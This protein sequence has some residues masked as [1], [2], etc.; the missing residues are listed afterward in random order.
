MFTSATRSP[1]LAVVLALITPVCSSAHINLQKIYGELTSAKKYVS[2]GLFYVAN[3]LGHRLLYFAA[4][5]KI[6]LPGIVCKF[7]LLLT[8]S[9]P[10]RK[11]WAQLP[12]TAR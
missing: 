5:L 11:V 6:H 4:I 2:S 3:Y 9:I 8:A 12:V 7:E 1:E 10:C